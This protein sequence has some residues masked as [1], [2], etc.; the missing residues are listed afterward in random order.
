VGVPTVFVRFGGC[1]LRCAGWPCDT[2]HAI[3]PAFREEW[4]LKSPEKLADEISEFGIKN[5]CFT[6]GEPFLQNNHALHE[7]SQLLRI[8]G[9]EV[10]CFSNGTLLY[11]KWAV[12]TINF[13]MD[14][15]LPGSGE[16]PSIW[17]PT[18]IKNM[19]ESLIVHSIKF[20]IASHE[21]YLEAKRR[22]VTEVPIGNPAVSLEF[23]YGVVWGQLEDKE[24]IEWVLK[25]GLRW[26]HNMQVHNYI[27]DRELRGI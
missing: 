8:R 1:N 11:P 15:K 4:K 5:I 21:D 7:L 16:E 19:D 26:R 10:E 14:W 9:M 13:V 12:D 27:W 18:N 6:G 25:D 22:W 23:F 17:T 2:Q 24:L 20:T 3:D